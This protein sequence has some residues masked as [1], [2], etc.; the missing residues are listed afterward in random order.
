MNPQQTN[1][2]PQNNLQPLP[3]NPQ[4]TSPNQ[5]QSAQQMNPASV[6][7]PQP[8]FDSSVAAPITT[9]QAPESIVP[10]AAMPT[11]NQAP[12]AAPQ[13]AGAAPT[14]PAGNKKSRLIVGIVA[15]VV[16]A[17]GVAGAAAFAVINSSPDKILTDAAINT[18]KAKSVAS[19]GSIIFEDTAN[20]GKVTLNFASKTISQKIEGSLDAELVV[21]YGS[22]STSVKGSGVLDKEGYGYVKIDD[23]PKLVSA[24][25]EYYV[26][27]LKVPAEYAAQITQP[28]DAFAKKIDGQWIKIDKKYFDNYLKDFESSRSC[29]QKATDTFSTNPAWQAQVADVYAKNKFVTITDVGDKYKDDNKDN[30]VYD[31][32]LDDDKAKQFDTAFAKETEFGKALEKCTKTTEED[33]EVSSETKVSDLATTVWIDRASRTFT[34]VKL[35]ASDKQSKF[36]V[37]ATLDT[38]QDTSITA[39]KATLTIEELQQDVNGI[40]TTLFGAGATSSDAAVSTGDTNSDAA[41]TVVKKAEVYNAIK[42][43]YPTLDQLKQ[44]GVEEARLDADLASRLSLSA[45]SVASPQT[46]QYELC[47]AGDWFV[48]YYWDESANKV[49]SY[50][51][52]A[53]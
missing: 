41:A 52:D 15:A 42:G 45:P 5:G 38:A 31:L 51:D 36:T 7:T 50:A 27:D 26:T 22:F 28:L 53:C 35:D 18:F 34:R 30:Y 11:I 43:A 25:N 12:L 10:A 23:A 14:E 3:E 20:K 40:L 9:L 47:T 8:A 48:V 33:A 46:I 44:G 21:D 49:A 17:L 37:D 32:K 4:V 39:P 13:P 19:K 2:E 16:I 24:L 29:S 1:P 6:D